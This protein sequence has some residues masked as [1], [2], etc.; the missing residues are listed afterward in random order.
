MKRLKVSGSFDSP[1]SHS[2]PEGMQTNMQDTLYELLKLFIAVNDVCGPEGVHV[3]LC[4]V[5]TY[6]CFCF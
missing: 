2:H 6:H 5:Y 1:H 4:H 3:Y